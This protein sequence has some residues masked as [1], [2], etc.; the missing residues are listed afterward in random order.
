MVEL[1]QRVREMEDKL[2]VLDAKREDD[3]KQTSHAMLKLRDALQTEQV[4]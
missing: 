2:L 1:T 4:C 3:A